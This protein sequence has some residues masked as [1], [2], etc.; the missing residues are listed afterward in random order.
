MSLIIIRSS[1]GR[2]LSGA[3]ANRRRQAAKRVR[4]AKW[5]QQAR[6]RARAVP[7]VFVYSGGKSRVEMIAA[8]HAQQP[9]FRKVRRQPISVLAFVPDAADLSMPVTDFKRSPHDM[10]D[11]RPIFVEV[12]QEMASEVR[13]GRID[14]EA[15]RRSL[16]GE[17]TDIIHHELN[18]WKRRHGGTELD[19]TIRQCRDWRMVNGEFTNTMF[20][21]GDVLI[22]V[23][24]L[25]R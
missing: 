8:A 24:Q 6:E 2:V 9:L 5:E 14:M 3:N 20:Y 16:P 21:R 15:S 11:G 18:G 17:I 12:S 7:A 13:L 10:F 22:Y 19:R 25:P 23:E 1:T 4:A